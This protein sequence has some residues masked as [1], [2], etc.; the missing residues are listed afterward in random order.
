MEWFSDFSSVLLSILFEALPF[1]LFG[2]LVSGLMEVLVP[3]ETLQRWIPRNR[4]AATAMG[5]LAGLAL[6]MCECGIVP[7]MRR[8]VRKGVPLHAAL[9]YMLA[10][11]IVNPIVI[12]STAFA[13]RQVRQIGPW[14]FTSLRVGLGV[15]IA[16]CGGLIVSAL[17]G[18]N[19]TW[20]AAS[21]PSS[22]SAPPL[23]RALP[24]ALRHAGRDFVEIG[25]FLVLGSAV[26]AALNVFVRREAILQFADN[27]V[28]STLAMM[29]LA[30]ALNLCSEA[31]AFVA[32]SFRGFSLASRL[33]FLVLGPML[34]LKLIAMYTRVFKKRT[35][36]LLCATT[37][38]LV[39]AAILVLGL[40]WPGLTQ[41][42]DRLPGS[43]AKTTEAAP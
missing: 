28:G 10:A 32:W 31:D 5:A 25:A 13:F 39:F 17:A 43:A 24:E 15:L 35:I 41:P 21:E 19:P 23:R 16:V 2:S 33:A 36:M 18:R 29:G 30:V 37:L 8:L 4:V 27:P 12:A 7:V 14:T 26:A 22:G 42:G 38:V 3:A 6:P 1:I 40:A 11:P 9:A 20:I 34:D